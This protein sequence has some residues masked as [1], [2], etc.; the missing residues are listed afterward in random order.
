MRTWNFSVTL[1]ASRA[2]PLYVQLAQALADA[3]RRGALKP[4]GALPGSRAFAAALGVTRNTV[5]AA[6][7]E[8]VA[9]GLAQTRGGAGTF[10]AT[11]P[12]QLPSI[13]MRDSD[14]PTYTL[15]PMRVAPPPAV[16][17]GVARLRL[18]A[19]MPDARLFPSRVFARAFRRALERPGR[20][21][22]GNADACGHRRLREELAG[23]L[24]Q[25]RGLAVTPDTLMITR[26]VEQGIDLVARCLVA[27]GDVVAIEAF[28]YPPAWRVFELAGARLVPLPLDDEGLDVDALEALV[29]RTPLRAVFLTPHHQFPTTAVMSPMRRERLARLALAHRFA[30][31]EDDY[32]HEFHYAGPPVQPIAAGVGRANAIYVGSLANLLAPGV[33]TAFVC[34]PPPMF[35]RLAALRAASDARGDAALECALA[36]LYVDGELLRHVRRMRG[37]YASR[38]DAFAQSLSRRLGAALAF[39]VPDGGLALWARADDGIDVGAWERECLAAGVVVRNARPFDWYGREQPYLRLGFGGHDAAELDDAA[40]RMAAALARVSRRAPSLPRRAVPCADA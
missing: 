37:V 20:G 5:V 35:G 14:A 12:P 19:G 6:Y 1:D 3:M 17:L 24:A 8:L 9:E 28:G 22:L 23:M 39:R 4:G 18:D 16:A 40:Q 33:A 31:V 32:D 38:R 11:A 27:P 13:A 2:L 34:A 21:G 10:V 30:I 15:P 25:T 26:S 7:D 36:E 29:A